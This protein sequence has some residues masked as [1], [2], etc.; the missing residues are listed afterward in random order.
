M[1]KSCVLSILYAC[2]VAFLTSNAHAAPT[3]IGTGGISL[4]RIDL[5]AVTA[6]N[7]TNDLHPVM[8]GI[9]ADNS[10][11][12]FTVDTGLRGGLWSIDP[13]TGSGTFIGFT[14]MRGGPLD[15]NN[16]TLI[17]GGNDEIVSVDINTAATTSLVTLDT[18]I[19]RVDGIAVQDSNT[20]I[21][22]E[23]NFGIPDG[24]GNSFLYSVDLT[25]GIQSLIGQLN[26]NI[27][28]IDFAPDGR[29]FGSNPGSDLYV[30]DI[31]TAETTLLGNTGEFYND[32]AIIP[33][34]AAAWLFGSALLGLGVIK[35]KKA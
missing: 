6:T 32:I 2:V 34:P 16:D 18:E 22:V 25:T 24:D 19:N 26:D 9:A 23:G 17:L 7:I 29:L 1:K 8:I 30:I 35:R 15:F 31:S 21:L 20:I 33:V 3:A 10:G 13:S 27:V 28:G 14:N 5:G 4:V 11:N 12:Y